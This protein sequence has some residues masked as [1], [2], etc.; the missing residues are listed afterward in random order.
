M[1]I[2]FF[3]VRGLFLFIVL[4]SVGNT[5]GQN[6]E[7]G[8]IKGHIEL[9]NNWDSKVYVSYIPTFSHMYSMSSDMIISDAVIDSLGYFEVDISFLPTEQQLFRLHITKKG[10]TPTSLIIGG[11]DE[12]HLF[13]VANR[14]TLIDFKARSVQQLFQDIIFNSSNDNKN[15]HKITKIVHRADSISSESSASKRQFIKDRMYEEL[16]SIADTTNNPL[17]SLYA[18]YNSNFEVSI[19]S[20]NEFYTSYLEKWK[21]QK[22][23]YFKAFREKI[24]NKKPNTNY[25]FYLFM[26]FVLIGVGFMMGKFGLKKNRRIRK[27]SVQERKI[28]LLLKQGASNQEISEQHNIG[29]STVKSHVSNIFTKLNVKSRREIM[30][31]K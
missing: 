15:F 3:N 13:F 17:V 21:D 29:I 30:N 22:N 5:N 9:N 27:L 14:Y 25:L 24:S 23:S 7:N 16:R 1:N 26:S 2:H 31:I 6:L 8:K 18:I 11:N 10:D 19:S 28:F 4:L 12:N 20:N